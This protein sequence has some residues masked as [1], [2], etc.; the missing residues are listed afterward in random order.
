MWTRPSVEEAAKLVANLMTEKEREAAYVW[1]QVH[2]GE[3]YANILKQIVLS[4][5]VKR[6]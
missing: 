5:K 6:K 3:D 2:C 1:Y 4:G